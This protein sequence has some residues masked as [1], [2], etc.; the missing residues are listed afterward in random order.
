MRVS[1]VRVRMGRSARESVCEGVSRGWRE[2]EH[3]RQ[4]DAPDPGP[5]PAD[6]FQGM[7]HTAHISRREGG[8]EREGEREGEREKREIAAIRYMYISMPQLH[9]YTFNNYV[10]WQP[11]MKVCPHYILVTKHTFLINDILHLFQGQIQP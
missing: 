5:W 11:G 2:G 4:S 1:E 10:V 9:V 6:L 7:T 3:L 8:A